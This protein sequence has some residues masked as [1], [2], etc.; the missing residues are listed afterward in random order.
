MVTLR[1]RHFQVWDIELS[2]L[3]SDLRSDDIETHWLIYT[4]LLNGG[5]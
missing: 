5:G 2:G 4:V 3:Y 1:E